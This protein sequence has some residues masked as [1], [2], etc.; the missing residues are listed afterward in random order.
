M[1]SILAK[2]VFLFIKN[3]QHQVKGK[4]HTEKKSQ[5]AATSVEDALTLTVHTNGVK[6]S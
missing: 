5:D 6:T 1:A 4:P 2:I 3:R